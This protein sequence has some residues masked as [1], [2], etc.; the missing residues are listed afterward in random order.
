MK[1]NPKFFLTVL[2]LLLFLLAPAAAE[3][4]PLLS[5]PLPIDEPFMP[6]SFSHVQD[7]LSTATEMLTLSIPLLPLSGIL[8]AGKQL[9]IKKLS[10]YAGAELLNYAAVEA[11]KAFF[12]RPRIFPDQSD[13]PNDSFPSGHTSAVW[14]GASFIT[15]LMEKD[16]ELAGEYKI[17][18]EAAVWAAAGITTALRV[19][20]G[21][22][23][24][25]DVLA[26]A[27]IG[28]GIGMLGGYLASL[29]D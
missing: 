8:S 28:A 13:E 11:L 5:G 22:H 16:P 10:L 25:S 7:S 2:F 9:S 29:I 20:S 18:V 4:P 6:D 23:Y 26:G 14:V 3:T 1:L 15:M 19:T 24:L 27:A 17:P 12:Q 21:E